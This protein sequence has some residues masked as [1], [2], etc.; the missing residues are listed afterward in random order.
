MCFKLEVKI[1]SLNNSITI[2]HSFGPIYFPLC[3]R[4]EYNNM[5]FICMFKLGPEKVFEMK[6]NAS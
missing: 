4:F 3:R 1:E 5:K 6:L 2:P